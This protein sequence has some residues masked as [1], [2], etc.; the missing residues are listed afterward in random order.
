L[1]VPFY[2]P[3]SLSGSNPLVDSTF[4]W[5]GDSH[6]MA[7]ENKLEALTRCTKALLVS[8]CTHAL[9]MA[10]ILAN[11]TPGDE[12]ILPSFTFV[13]AANAIV[14][15]GGIP[16]FVDCRADNMN[17]DERLIEQAITPKTKAIIV[18]HYGGLQC[19]MDPIMTLATQHDLIVIEDAAHSIY[20]FHNRMHLGTRGHM[21]TLSFHHTKNIQCG[22]GGALLINDQ[23]FVERSYILRDKGTNRQSFVQGLTKQY[24]WVDVGS[25]YSL[26]EFSAA[27]LVEQLDAIE[28]ITK[29]RRK[30]WDQYAQGVD[31]LQLNYGGSIDADHN[32]H[33]FYMLLASN[34]LRQTMILELRQL[35]I[36][37]RFHYV[38][39]HQSPFGSQYKFIQ[40]EN[41]TLS[42]AS[43]LIRLPLFH[44]MTE[45]QVSYVLESVTQIQGS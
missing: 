8:S 26:S 15:R 3:T 34:E 19:E 9:E 30:L 33:I 42:L 22:K 6:R 18:M 23:R 5:A 24:S 17:I 32:G 1:Q 45:A 40:E 38:P 31:K 39:L 14:L 12:V 2:K 4:N 28:N 36:D 13:S 10:V 16:V 37:A 20:A 41:R 21:S 27:I 29:H 25:S 44:E 7:C 43:R 11:L 35:G